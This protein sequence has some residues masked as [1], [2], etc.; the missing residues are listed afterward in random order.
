MIFPNIDLSQ[1]ITTRLAS[2]IQKTQLTNLVSRN[3]MS[4]LSS[5]VSRRALGS[6]SKVSGGVDMGHQ[7]NGE[8]IP[9]IYGYVGMT[10]TQFDQG[11]K[12]SE[13]DTKKTVQ[14][15]RVAISEGPI[16]GVSFTND[17]INY[18]Y[19]DYNANNPNVFKGVVVDNNYV[20]DP[21]TGVANYSD[22][23]VRMTM[24]DGSGQY[25]QNATIAANNPLT[26][27]PID[28]ISDDVN[29]RVLND[30]GD[31]QAGRGENNV[32][33]WN[34]AT[35]QWEAKAFNTLLNEA[36]L[37]YQGG[38]G[39]SGGS[40]G[41]GGQGGTGGTGGVGPSDGT[42]IKYTQWNPPPAHV[43]VINGAKT[44]RTT[45]INPPTVAATITC[46]LY[47]SPSPRDS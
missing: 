22:I 44:E 31:V 33:Y 17:Y 3:G 15:L 6:P 37:E 19:A 4:S 27:Q 25:K 9:I 1:F 39:G 2:E 7:M 5:S 24:G 38:A 10:N 8:F 16:G 41:S 40:G 43:E 26:D 18:T 28:S 30:L 14:Q 29:T 34:H 11:Q 20:I 13:V 12:P 47:T 35:S 32:L 21:K 42:G 36:G 45:Y 23:K 46:L